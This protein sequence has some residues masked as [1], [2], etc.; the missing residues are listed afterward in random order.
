MMTIIKTHNGNVELAYDAVG[1]PDGQPLLLI[2]G[3]GGQL[4][5]WPDGFC[6]LLVERGFQV[7]RFDNRD[8]GES[9]HFTEA[10]QPNQLKMLL[11]PAAAAEYSL[12]DM[13]DDAIAV[14]DAMGW[15]SAHILGTSQGGMIGQTM[16]LKHPERVRTLTS[17]S[18]APGARIGQPGLR[19]LAKIVKVANPKRVKTAEDLGQYLVDLDTVTGSP[20]YPADESE[21]RERGRRAFARGGMTA[22][23]VQR[24]TA[25]IAAAGDRRAELAAITAPTLVLHGEDDRMIRVEAAR[26]TA[27]A[28]PGAR[29][30][31]YPGMGHD[32]PREL[33]S[34]IADEISTLAREATA[35]T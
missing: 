10:G 17:L 29:L 26:A 34:A 20:A 7:A 32:M 14:M 27:E 25:A 3:I 6:Q 35:A 12:D 1:P 33:W 31:T 4:I 24:Q 23:D 22:A 18:S 15:P 11:K 30:V 21:L 9:T 28:I 13:A 16:A 2:M 19:E 5:S 8:S